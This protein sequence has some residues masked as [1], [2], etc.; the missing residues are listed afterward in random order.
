M[1]LADESP[2]PPEHHPLD[3]V[4][5]WAEDALKRADTINDYTALLVKR[6]RIGDKLQD[7]QYLELKIRN[8][9]F[10]VYI[11][12]LKPSGLAG[13]E[14]IYVEGQHDGNLLAH[15][16]SGLSEILGTVSLAPDGLI[17]MHGQRYPITMIGIKN[18][19][20]RLIEKAKH[21]RQTDDPCEIK[22]FQ[23]A[24]VDGRPTLCVEV[25]HPQRRPEQTFAMARVYVDQKLG[26]PIRY[27]GYAWPEK[28]GD[29]PELIE[30]YTYSNI[31]TNVG[32]ADRDFDP[33][34]PAYRF[35]SP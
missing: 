15:D 19:A 26:I 35:E 7:Y 30:E 25:R 3:P 4:I 24:K 13:R 32:L 18:L 2:A 10:S 21:D 9:P 14:I 33:K 34:N 8:Q 31:R 6:E 29:A 17:A 23:N 20:T 22:W 12:F 27:E 1:A 16:G 5:A 11:K 28:S